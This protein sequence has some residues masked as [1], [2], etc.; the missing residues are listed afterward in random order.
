LVHVA[1]GHSQRG[2]VLADGLVVWTVKQ[3]VHL[4]PALWYSSIWR[5]PN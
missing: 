4:A 3:A 2:V 5:T 1:A